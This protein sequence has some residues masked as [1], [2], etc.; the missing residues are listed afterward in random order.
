VP[1]KSVEQ[2]EGLV[3]GVFGNVR[4]GGDRP[5]VDEDRQGRE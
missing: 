5:S 2:V 3:F 4:G 1:G